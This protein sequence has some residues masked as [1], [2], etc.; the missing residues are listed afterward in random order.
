MKKLA[1]DLLANNSCSVR[2]VARF[3][4]SLT[5][6]FE[7][8]PGGRLHYR[9]KCKGDYEP[10]CSLSDKAKTEIKWR[11]ENMSNSFA[12]MKSTLIMLFTLVL[13]TWDGEHPIGRRRIMAD[14]L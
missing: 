14:G 4:G 3:I 6:S 7:A 12:Y 8:V 1:F 5:A 10:P 11:V 2:M 9:Q 13:V